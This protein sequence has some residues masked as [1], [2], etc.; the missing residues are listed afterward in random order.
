MMRSRGLYC[1][2]S[3]RL[4]LYFKI[5]GAIEESL[6]FA[7]APLKG[8]YV[9]QAAL[10]LLALAALHAAAQPFMPGQGLP[11]LGDDFFAA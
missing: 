10:C 9:V 11:P 2:V 6:A 4:V 5:P 3:R 1:M 8:R 7:S